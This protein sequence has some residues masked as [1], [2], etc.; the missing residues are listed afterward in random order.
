MGR[1]AERWPRPAGTMLAALLCMLAPAA[2]AGQER[3]WEDDLDHL[4]D[5]VVHVWSSPFRADAEDAL[6]LAAHGAVFGGLYLAD[7][8]IQDWVHAHHDAPYVR[9]LAVVGHDS[10]LNLVGR[11]H[12]ISSAGTLIWLV[13][14]L[15]EDH[16]LRDAGLGCVTSNLATTLSRVGL[17]MLVNRAR[18][19]TDR[20][21]RAWDV[22]GFGPW[23]MRSFPGGHAA[24]GMSCASFLAHRFE[25]GVVEP[26]IYGLAGSMG[27]ARVRDGAHWTSD[28]FVGMA[29]G[30]HVGRAVADR[31]LARQERRTVD[32]ARALPG[33][34]VGARVRF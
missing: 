7:G 11:T 32:G 16:D 21:P 9:W 24:N 17:A 20:G 6:R 4:A 12:F 13:G 30:W 15:A 18:P 34:V 33:V 31:F 5:D 1:D 2:A 19:E 28:T 26:A 8:A 25:W 22:P 10:P 3:A 14:V 29:W 27:L 23:E